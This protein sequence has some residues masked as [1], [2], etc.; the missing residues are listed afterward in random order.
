M[1]TDL[2]ER[3]DDIDEAID[4]INM[5]INELKSIQMNNTYLI[6]KLKDENHQI[7]RTIKCLCT[8]ILI[9]SVGIVSCLGYIYS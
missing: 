3:M 1:I 5:K 6:M 4:I 7:K 8:M 9:N 2:I